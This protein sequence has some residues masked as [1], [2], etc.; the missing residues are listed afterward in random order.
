MKYFLMVIV[1]IVQ[2]NQSAAQ[3]DTIDYQRAEQFLST[4]L[5]KKYYHSYVSPQWDN[6]FHLLWYSIHTKRGTEYIKIDL[7]SFQKEALFDQIELGK[8]LSELLDETIHP[9]AL[10]ISILGLDKENGNIRLRCKQKLHVFNTQTKQLSEY[11]DGNKHQSHVSISPDKQKKITVYN[12]NIWLK[13][14]KQD[15]IQITTDGHMSYGY[16]VSPS[17]Y[18]VKNIED[19]GDHALDLDINWSP[20][21]DY[22]IVGRYDRRN[23]KNLYLYKS[24]PEKGNRSEIYSYERPLAGDSLVPTV[25]YYLIDIEKGTSQHINLKPLATFLTSSFEWNKK[26][27]K[28]YQKRYHRG[29]QSM[30]IIEL[31]IENNVCQTIY[32]ESSSTYV[33][34]LNDALQILDDDSFLW[35]SEKDGWNHIYRYHI[36]NG[37]LIQQVTKGEFVVR[38]IEYVDSKSKTIYFTACGMEQGLD[39]YYPMLYSIKFNGQNLKQLTPEKAHHS[40]SVSEEYNV[41][42]DNFS[43]VR[44]PNIAVLRSLKDG[45]VI[46]TLE[47]GDISEILEMGWQTPEPFVVKGRDGT[48]DIYGV[49]YKPVNFDPNKLY[50]IIEGT[51]SGPQTIRTPKTFYR[52]LLNDDTPLAQL[53]FV[54][55]NI[56]GMGTAFR[57]KAFHDVSYKNLGDIGGPDKIIAIKK[58]AENYS[59]MDTTRVGIFG[60]SAGGYDAAR[61]LLAYPEFYKVAVA[62]AGNHD[63]RA[64]KAWWPE[65]YMGYPAGPHYDEQSNYINAHKLQ[66]HLMLVHGDM[67]QNVNPTSSM[68]LADELIKANKDFELLILPNKDHSSAYYDKYLIRKRWDFFVRHLMKANPPKNFNIQ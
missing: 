51:Y 59:W 24:L 29:Y 41:F 35:L 12:Y 65:L 31:D 44:E 57:S 23:A 25:E 67:D 2:I 34:P 45:K 36:S 28:A 63:H 9:F 37:E 56:D 38:S 66:G 4:R 60:H 49:I 40:V 58:L 33:D 47:Q 17:W 14:G 3:I 42:V 64:A 48:T 32:S 21:N 13:A 1:A 15:S 39:P 20:N 26:G 52:G 10:P 19:P 8:Q 22:A 18:S 46:K 30:D 68:R 50:P 53:G 27:D 7:K 61:A 11:E 5:S 6:N 62:T 54:L 55:I 16:G 43:T